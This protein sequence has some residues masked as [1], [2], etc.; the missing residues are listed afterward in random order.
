MFTI[1]MLDIAVADVGQR[2]LHEWPPGVFR[3][4]H[5]CLITVPHKQ[6]VPR[7]TSIYRADILTCPLH[8]QVKTTAPKRYCVKPSAVRLSSTTAGCQLVYDWLLG[9][10]ILHTVHA[11]R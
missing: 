9:N 7:S 5:P 2:M 1:C 10:F 3:F 11:V 8:M 6:N 4:A